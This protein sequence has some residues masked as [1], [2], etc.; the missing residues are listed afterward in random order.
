MKIRIIET[1]P[2]GDEYETLAKWGSSVARRLWD[3][4]EANPHIAWDYMWEGVGGNRQTIAI[5]MEDEDEGVTPD[6]HCPNCMCSGATR[7][8]TMRQTFLPGMEPDTNEERARERVA[9]EASTFMCRYCIHDNQKRTVA[10]V[11]KDNTFR[12]YTCDRVDIR[13]TKKLR[14]YND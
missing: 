11:E 1:W 3:R 4:M 8:N 14:L 2:G 12:C 13:R 7:G 9:L 10:F 6:A 5:R